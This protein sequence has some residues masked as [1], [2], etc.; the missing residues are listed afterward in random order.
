MKA[1]IRNGEAIA[2]RLLK[3][4]N[5]VTFDS[6]PRGKNADAVQSLRVVADDG[7][8]ACQ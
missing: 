1:E 5:C 3:K 4:S 6:L 7:M 8:M 2:L